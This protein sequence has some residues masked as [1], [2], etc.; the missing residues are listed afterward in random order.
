MTAP[1]TP[2]RKGL[3]AFS[4]DPFDE[5]ARQ[6]YIDALTWAREN[7]GEHVAD[8]ELREFLDGVIYAE[9]QG[10][11]HIIVDGAGP[12][13]HILAVHC[14]PLGEGLT[15]NA[16]QRALMLTHIA[17]QGGAVWDV[18]TTVHKHRD[19]QN[20]LIATSPLISLL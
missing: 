13:H 3:D 19:G 7:L 12:E 20:W 10:A 14:A 16:E 8:P 6:D 17:G 9:L 2:I 1:A 15:V 18:A 5:Q 4:Q 11:P